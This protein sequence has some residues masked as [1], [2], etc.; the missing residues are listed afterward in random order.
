MEMLFGSNGLTEFFLFLIREFLIKTEPILPNFEHMSLPTVASLF[1][2]I[3]NFI[4][5]IYYNATK[6]F[7]ASL[8]QCYISIQV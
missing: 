8:I 2:F 6:S 1:V 4:I 5:C 7:S 3:I